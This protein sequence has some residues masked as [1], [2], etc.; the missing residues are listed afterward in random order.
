MIGFRG[1]E[2]RRWNNLSD[3]GALKTAGLIEALFDRFGSSFL[4][5]GMVEN[6]GAVLGA[7]VVVL[8]IR[9]GGIVHAKEV[10]EN[11]LIADFRWIK[12]DLDRFGMAGCTS[13]TC[14]YVGLGTLPPV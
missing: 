7:N 4:F 5:F 8:A 14:L 6:R 11:S 3:D 2:I 13:A 10:V 12:N 1:V 9:G